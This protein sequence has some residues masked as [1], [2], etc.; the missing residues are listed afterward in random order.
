MDLTQYL[1][2]PTLSDYTIGGILLLCLIIS[3]YYYFRYFQK[4]KY[5]PNPL[6]DHGNL[7]PVSILI[8]AKNELKHLQEHLPLW[9]SQ[10]YPHFEVVIVD[11]GS[12]DGSG[13]WV[14]GVHEQDARVKAVIMDADY[15]KYKGKKMA[16]TLAI[17]AAKYHHFLL[18]DADCKP[19]SQNWLRQMAGQFSNST[20]LV[21][22]YSPIVKSAG[23]LNAFIRFEALQSALQYI[24]H[25]LVG[26][27]YMG[28][29]RNL[30]YSREAYDR[31]KGFSSHYHIPAGDDDLFVQQVAN[32]KNTAVNI[33]KDAWV[34]TSGKTQW[35]HWWQQKKRHLFVGKY[36]PT[37][38]RNSL[39]LFQLTQLL[40]WLS[41]ILWFVAGSVWIYPLLLLMIKITPE[42]II[43]NKKSKVLG[44]GDLG[45]SYPIMLFLFTFIY[46]GMGIAAFFAKK[47][48]W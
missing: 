14:A 10:D 13:E 25:A 31:V 11:D 44:Q 33:E 48:N 5:S 6:S 4:V 20:E 15:I 42:W 30:A 9:L 32:A 2:L 23:I 46:A 29:G 40:F 17:K 16:L 37:G 43:W 21:I 8:C 39:S 47:I 7:P 3:W 28:V 38:I 34:F 35:R 36:Y 18:T 1:P 41:L 45:W 24:G 19:A 27:P 22:G 26:K 12:M